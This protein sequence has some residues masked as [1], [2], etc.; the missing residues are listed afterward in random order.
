MGRKKKEEMPVVESLKARGIEVL[1]IGKATED[2]I[3][4]AASLDTD[5]A[6]TYQLSDIAG[7]ILPAQEQQIIL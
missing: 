2:A 6:E 5:F 1:P 3:L 4:D 7:K